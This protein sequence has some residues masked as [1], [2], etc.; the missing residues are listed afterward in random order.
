[1]PDSTP[2]EMCDITMHSW[3]SSSGSAMLHLLSGTV[4]GRL[5]FLLAASDIANLTN[6]ERP[7]WCVI[8]V[9]FTRKCLC[10]A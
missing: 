3:C 4:S 8:W 6:A 10:E 7:I 9:S 2:C 1:M 5:L